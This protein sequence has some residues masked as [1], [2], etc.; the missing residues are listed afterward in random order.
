MSDTMLRAITLCG[1]F[2]AVAAVT[3]EV[4]EALRNRHHML[5]VATAALGRS[6]TGAFLLTRE[7]KGKERVMIQVLGDGPLGEIFVEADSSGNGRGYVG[8][9]HVNLPGEGRKIQVGKGVG[10]RGTLTVIKDLA[11]KEPYRGVVPITSGEIGKDLAYYLTVSEQIPSAVALGVYI[12]QDL[13]VGVAGGYMVNTLPGATEEEI[14][15]VEENIRNLPPPTA[16]IR[17]GASPQGM[18]LKVLEGFDLKFFGDQPL[19]FQ[20]R[21]SRE[22]LSK[23]LL[24]MGSKELEDMQRKEGSVKI[25]CEFCKETYVFSGEAIRVLLEAATWNE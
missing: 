24:A 25:T 8:N 2:M 4:V 10:T 1:R 7:L 19:R 12:E 15:L 22:R 14:A 17:C 23:A 13:T 16:L 9:P 5:P 11:L 20:C 3:T 18:L 6:L 21:C